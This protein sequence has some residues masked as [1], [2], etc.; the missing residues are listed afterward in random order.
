MENS[1]L[2]WKAASVSMCFVLEGPTG[3]RATVVSRAVRSGLF[4]VDDLQFVG[5]QGHEG[6]PVLVRGSADDFPL[7]DELSSKINFP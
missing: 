7:L 2:T 5:V 3:R 1:S 4:G 6:T